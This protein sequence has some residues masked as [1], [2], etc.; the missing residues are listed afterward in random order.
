MWQ[1]SSDPSERCVWPHQRRTLY[2]RPDRPEEPPTRPKTLCR[3]GLL[4]D[5]PPVEP[6]LGA[7]DADASV[8]VHRSQSRQSAVLTPAA[9]LVILT[10]RHS[11]IT[12][13]RGQRSCDRVGLPAQCE[14]WLRRAGYRLPVSCRDGGHGGRRTRVGIP[15]IRILGLLVSRI[16]WLASLRWLSK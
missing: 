2:L 8:P 6:E 9:V 11:A 13:G 4:A 1:E 16:S 5:E 14:P 3:F 10:R 12:T 7:A 15:G